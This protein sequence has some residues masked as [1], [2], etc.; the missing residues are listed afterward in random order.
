MKINTT[1]KLVA[2]VFFGITLMLHGQNKQLRAFT[3]EDGLPQSQVFSMIQ[4]EKGYLWLGTQGGGLA[5][6][7]GNT[8]KVFNDKNGLASNYINSLLT[9]NNILYLGTNIGLTIKLKNK[10]L[11]IE[12]PEINKIIQLDNHVFLLTKQGVYEVRDS[13][14]IKKLQLHP[15]IDDFQVND[16]RFSNG[17]Y[18]LATQEGLWQFT[19][20][21]H[22]PKAIEKLE[23][24]DFKALADYNT[25]IIAST[26]NDGTLVFEFDDFN[27]HILIREPLRIN[28][29]SI[30]NSNQLWVATDANG[31]TVIDMDTYAELFT[32]EGS[33][34]LSTPN[35][36]QVLQ[37][38][39]S[40]IWIAT[41]GG[42]L[43]K[44]FQ[45]NFKHFNTE[46]GLNG[47]RVYAVHHSNNTI[48]ISNS[49]NGLMK[50]DN[51]G[52]HEVD[53]PE[54]FS[55][56]KIKTITSDLKG[57]IWAGSD[58][59]GLL[60]KGKVSIDSFAVDTLKRTKKAF[61]KTKM[62][63]KVLSTDTGFPFDWIRKLHIDKNIMYAATYSS[64]IVRFNYD[65]KTD[66]LTVFK[67]FA[68]AEGIQ[69]LYLKDM[70]KAEDGRLW[71]TTQNGHL[72]YL[73]NNTI[74]HFGA[75]L[76]LNVPI[77]TILFHQN[78]MFLGTAGKG[79][80][81]S[82][83]EDF[84]TF[85]KLKGLK[86]GSSENI[87]Q[88]IFD[89]Q[90]Y[91]W[92]GTEKGVDKLELDKDNEI[93]DAFFF[94]R[95]DGFLGVETCL[96]AVDK[97]DKGH[98]WFGALYGL[99]E[100]QPTD[101]TTETEQPTIYLE[102][103]KVAYKSVDSI[104]VTNW[105]NTNKVLQL[106]PDQKQISFSYKTVD[107]DHPNG[108]EYRYK[109]NDTD[110]SPWSTS[111][112]QDFSELNYGAHNFIVQ[113]RNHRWKESEP[114]RFSFHIERPL[115]KKGWFQWT[116]IGLGVLL[117]AAITYQ[118]IK[119]IKRKNAQE[120]ERLELENHLLTLEQKALRLQ[121][122]PHFIFNVL[123]GIKAMAPTKPE[124]MNET[125][126]SFATL[127]RETLV[128]S[129]KDTI[130]LDQELKTLKHYIEV[131]RLMAEKPF[132]Y[133]ITLNTDLDEEEILIPPML[134]QPFVE[135]A[136][137]HGILKGPRAGELRIQFDTTDDVLKVSISDN[138]IGIYNSQ[139]QKPKTD[140]QSMALKVTRERLES[141]S[142]K[143]ALEISELKNNDGTISGTT[144]VFRI[145]LETDY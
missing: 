116:I 36:R 123:N 8:F 107:I 2:F 79:I 83:D 70:A 55:E 104:H 74:T 89:N 73:H 128:N 47:N 12:T 108:V 53:L 98:L 63:T 67:T 48:W 101:N 16:L 85:K 1:Y 130:S 31:V 65:A 90:G 38:R 80:W 103:V 77:N 87:Y 132:E 32:L 102:D 139:Q 71:Y 99:T 7:D 117:L 66:S 50:I 42:G 127:L 33:N 40:N 25:K 45:N 111:E 141:I 68:T 54:A 29:I 43:Y 88:L 126:N 49:E 52:I 137:R 35:I 34:G 14:A 140:H 60:F 78:T 72:G 119:R 96:N 61:P 20:S 97:D 51:Y 10:F 129:R 100:Y 46:T 91:L 134:I 22:Q 27:N 64:G 118:Y 39:Q 131:E 28:S 11:N 5:Q 58:G 13:F 30:L 37:D 125:V 133:T 21:L 94:G 112:T 136:I 26:F 17:K 76:D 120:K 109:L 144:I 142:G 18:W 4:D 121:M 113:S 81:W 41:S 84:S 9:V 86:S 115:Y 124:K 24:G 105:T 15:E 3:L 95:N 75:V 69:D 138:G 82:N 62:I 56:V 143:E 6:F 122:N 93:K 57:N 92:V 145:P 44:Y 135:N 19:G 23:R 59:R 114:L 110:W 106:S